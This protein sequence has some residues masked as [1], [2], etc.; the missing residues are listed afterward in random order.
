VIDI[1]SKLLSIKASWVEKLLNS[2][3]KLKSYV[4]SLCRQHNIDLKYILLTN[5]TGLKNYDLV[6]NFPNFYQ[7][8]FICY[9]KCKQKQKHLSATEFL[10]QPIWNNQ[11]FAFKGR[12]PYF[13]EWIKSDLLYVKDICDSKGLFKVH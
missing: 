7:K 3:G 10:L 6:R 13:P 12:S 8:N 5:E 1:E 2:K 11:L 9:N 4:D